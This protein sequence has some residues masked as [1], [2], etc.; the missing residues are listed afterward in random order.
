MTIDRRVHVVVVDDRPDRRQVL[1]GTLRCGDMADADVSEVDG[2]ALASAVVRSNPVDAVLVEIGVPGAID[3]IAE[4]RQL[5]AAM[6]ILVCSFNTDPKVR[7][8]AL[9]AGATAYLTKPVSA[10]QLHRAITGASGT[11]GGET[12]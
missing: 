1:I 4:V 12:P 2:P 9:A 8:R 3:L 6:V 5:D 7:E 11:A 10:R